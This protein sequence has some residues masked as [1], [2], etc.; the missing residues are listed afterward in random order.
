MGCMSHDVDRVEPLRAL[1]QK[2]PQNALAHYMLA[3]EYLKSKRYREALS[4]LDIYF[5]MADDEGAG[6]RMAATAHLG[7][8]AED[9]A[10]EAYR[11]GIEAATRHHHPSMVE[12]FEAA[13]AELS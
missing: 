10:R 11:K 7:L 3:N 13:V 5:G 9:A 1:V 8:G 2:D 6:Y 4:E 12:E